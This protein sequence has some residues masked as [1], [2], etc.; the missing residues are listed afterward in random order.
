M[1]RSFW[2]G[3]INFGLVHIP[4]HMKKAV[5][6][7][8]G[9]HF[10]EL[11]DKDHVPLEQ[12]RVCPADG[13]EVP[14]NHVVK[15]YEVSP[16]HF[17]VLEKSELDALKEALPQTIDVER[18]V[19]PTEIHPLYLDDSYYVLPQPGAEKPYGLLLEAMKETGKV[20]VVKLVMRMNEHL[21]ILRP[22]NRVFS[23]TRLY[24]A[25]EVIEED[26]LSDLPRKVVPSRSE[27]SMATQ[28]IK[29][30][31]GEFELARFHDEYRERVKDLI[32]RKSEGKKIPAEKPR[33]ESAR[34]IDL[35]DA[36]KASLDEVHE[37]GKAKPRTTGKKAARRRK[38]A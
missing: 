16:D 32:E 1:A 29:S 22:E 24:Y 23:L 25:D 21:S 13:K 8:A 28:L 5:S 3:S 30:L 14:Y 6:S 35:M 4:V 11:H 19:D 34:V 7:K 12:K 17:V 38:A 15:G 33:R 27:M 37:K 20:A 18:F 26:E 36:L 2:K 9:L 31:S 10:R